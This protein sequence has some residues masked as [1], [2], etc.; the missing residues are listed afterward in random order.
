MQQSYEQ[1]KEIKEKKKREKKKKKQDE[2]SFNNRG[3]IQRPLNGWTVGFTEP[4]N[5]EKIKIKLCTA[6]CPGVQ[7]ELN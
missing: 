2:D 4:N 6:D 3:R 1:P 5:G 7:K